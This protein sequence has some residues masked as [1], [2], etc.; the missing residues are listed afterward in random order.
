LEKPINLNGIESASQIAISPN[1]NYLAIEARSSLK[2][3][4]FVLRLFDVNQLLKQ[5]PKYVVS[6]EALSSH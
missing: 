3:R 4:T 6:D 2:R 1:G 5:M